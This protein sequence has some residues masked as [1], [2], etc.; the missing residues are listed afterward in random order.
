MPAVIEWVLGELFGPRDIGDGVLA[1][2][3]REIDTERDEVAEAID[4]ASKEIKAR[5]KVGDSGR[6]E[7]SDRF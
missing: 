7:G 3:D 4:G 1:G 2:V 5:A 6:C